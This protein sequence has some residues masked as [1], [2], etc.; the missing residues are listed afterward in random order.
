MIVEGFREEI[1]D[2]YFIYYRG[3]RLIID[4]GNCDGPI[5][6]RGLDSATHGRRTT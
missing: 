6:P 1:I 5:S 3:S 4:T 2:F